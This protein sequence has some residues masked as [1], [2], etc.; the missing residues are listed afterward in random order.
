ARLVDGARRAA[1]WAGGDDAGHLRRGH[2]SV[3]ALHG[4]RRLHSWLRRRRAV[5]WLRVRERR[6]TSR[7]PRDHAQDAESRDAGLRRRP[8]HA[9]PPVSLTS[10]SSSIATGSSGAT[11]G[12]WITLPSGRKR[13]PWHGQSHVDADGFQATM[14]PRWVQTA[15]THDTAPSA[16]RDTANFRPPRLTTAPALR[17]MASTESV[18]PGV[19]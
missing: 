11:A 13:E 18:S 16:P 15:D 5:R 1:A 2:R 7:R 6:A 10:S 17:G 3:R 4:G 12:P 8:L 9:A 19:S 14:Q